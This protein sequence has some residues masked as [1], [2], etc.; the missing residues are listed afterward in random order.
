[1]RQQ[2][3]VAVSIY[4]KINNKIKLACMYGTFLIAK[5]KLSIVAA[6]C[7]ATLYTFLCKSRK[8]SVAR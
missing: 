4:S 6:L 7:D 1:M 8:N 5:R 2:F 3:M